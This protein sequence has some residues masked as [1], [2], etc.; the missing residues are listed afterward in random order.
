MPLILKT[1][2]GP[3]EVSDACVQAVASRADYIATLTGEY[4]SATDLFPKTDKNPT[5][6][7]RLP[8]G[9]L[10]ELGAVLQIAVWERTGIR[11]HIDAGLPSYEEAA[12]DLARRASENPADF[13]R[14]ESATLL[15][16]VFP[17]WVE[18]FAWGG[19]EVFAA[20]MQID[21][22]EEDAL[23]NGLAE[24][25][26]RHRDSQGPALQKGDSQHDPEP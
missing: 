6:P 26:W 12:A 23:V 13:D 1:T 4:L 7:V 3:L 24:F 20:E 21:T 17:L 15:R 19:P 11:T 2:D 5:E 8:A 16:R 9:F 14:I 22:A 10:L 18:R 25:L